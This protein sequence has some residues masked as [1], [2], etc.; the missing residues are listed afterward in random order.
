MPRKLKADLALIGCTI[1]WGVTFVIVKDALADASVF[2]FLVLRFAVAAAVLAIIYKRELHD[3]SAGA[4]RAGFLIG[5]LLFAGFGFQTVGLR[6]TTPSKAAFIT[7]FSVILVPLLLS[8]FGARRINLAVWVGALSAFA[9]LYY[10]TAPAHNDPVRYG[11]Q[12]SAHAVAQSANF[13]LGDLLVL[14]CAIVF[15][16][17]VIAIGHFSPRYSPGVLTLVQVAVAAVLSA[18][19]IPLMSVSRL[20]PPRLAATPR[21]AFAIVTTGLFATALAFLGQVWAQQYT[22]SSHTAI[23]F[24]LEPVFAGLTSFAFY[25][26][27]LGMRGLIG[28]ALILAGIVLAELRG[29]AQTPIELT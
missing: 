2:V 21:L 7:G 28:A 16:V 22:T 20:E 9:G 14:C 29:P 24:A 15:A 19:A 10:L 27:R 18:I 6:F 12:S 8:L 1:I 13:N 5:C 17:H 11:A 3:M 4:A 26:E 25:H 23:I